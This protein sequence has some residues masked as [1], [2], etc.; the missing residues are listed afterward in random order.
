M[1]RVAARGVV[2]VVAHIR[3]VRIGIGLAVGVAVD[4]GER[5]IICRIDVAIPARTPD[6]G[7]RSRINREPGV[8]EGGTRPRGGVVAQRAGGGERRRDVV[9]VGG[10]LVILLVAGVAGRGRVCVLPVDMATGAGHGG[11]RPGQ[12][13]A[14]GVVIEAGRNPGCGAVA[15]LALLREARGRVIGI[16]GVLK[17]LQVA[18]D[19]G[20]AQVGELPIRMA[21]LALQRGV[22]PGEGET[23]QRVVELSIGPGS[24]AV[25]DG[26]VRRESGG[27]VIGIRRLLEVRH[28]ARRT[29]GRHGAVAAVDMALRA[30][31]LHVRA[32]QRPACHGMVKIHVH[33]RTGAVA[34]GA[35]GGKSRRDVIGIVGCGPILGVATQAIHRRALEAPSGM[36]GVAVQRGVHAGERK[37]GEPQMI[38]FRPEPRIHAVAFLAGTGES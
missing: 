37:A 7:V 30:G 11:V 35:T 18:G 17:I 25:A 12:G 4:A 29:G 13:E 24:C 15:H 2:N 23:G 9:G 38:K 27:G 19:T 26:A 20:R 32:G 36:T 31:H 28:V 6:S 8:I 22:R 34:G 5:G 14:G 33:P 3:V 10:A 21:A 1:A 16:I